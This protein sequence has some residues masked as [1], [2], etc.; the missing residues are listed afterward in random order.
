MCPQV[1]DEGREPIAKT[2]GTD[3]DPASVAKP[4]LL[5]PEG[6]REAGRENGCDWAGGRAGGSS[7]GGRAAGAPNAEWRFAGGGCSAEGGASG[8]GRGDSGA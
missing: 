1:V 7:G 4:P 3:G 5:L 8:S 6:C 2:V